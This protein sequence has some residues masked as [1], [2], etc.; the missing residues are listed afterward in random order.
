MV[1][2]QR[3][4]EIVN[5]ASRTSIWGT[6]VIP[7]MASVAVICN[8]EVCPGE[9]IKRIVVI[10]RR[11][12]SSLRMTAFAISGELCGLVVGVARGVI[13][14]CMASI[15]GVGGVVVIAVVAGSTVI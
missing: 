8:G 12:P 9:W 11:C 3:L 10:C 1:G 6:G 15:T 2:V 13:I 7:I 14:I 5:V 4:I